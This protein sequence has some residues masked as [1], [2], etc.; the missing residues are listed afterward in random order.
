MPDLDGYQATREIRARGGE[1]SQ[2]PIV[3]LTASAMAEDR[4][5]CFAAGM[6]DF[7][8]KPLSVNSLQNALS[9]WSR[10]VQQAPQSQASN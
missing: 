10:A 8:S 1:F 2:I 3:A 5:R 7:L 4:Q 9:R 6:N